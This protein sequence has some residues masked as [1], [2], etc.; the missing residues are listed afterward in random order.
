MRYQGRRR[1][2]AEPSPAT[3]EVTETAPEAT[4]VEVDQ[5]REV[6]RLAFER[7]KAAR[8]RNRK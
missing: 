1:R 4:T 8:E 7:I 5:I 6:A 2:P 3:D